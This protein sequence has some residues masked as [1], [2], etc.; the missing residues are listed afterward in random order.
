[1]LRIAIRAACA[2]S[3]ALTL[4][5]CAH[6]NSAPA[7][8]KVTIGRNCEKLAQEV[9][10]PDIVEGGDVFEAVAEHRVVIGQLN[11]NVRATR[12]CQVKQRKRPA[13]ER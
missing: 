12:T 8:P 3:I 4:S 7:S 6:S 9:P 13:G 2:S 1:M 5:A 11:R 10:A